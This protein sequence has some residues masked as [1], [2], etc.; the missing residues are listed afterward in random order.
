[1][2]E[3]QNK[4]NSEQTILSTKSNEESIKTGDIKNNT[5]V[6][7]GS[8][9]T[10][11]INLSIP[12]LVIVLIVVL[13][14]CLITITLYQ[15]IQPI[16]KNTEAPITENNGVASEE[17]IVPISSSQGPIS[18]TNTSTSQNHDNHQGLHA[19]GFYLW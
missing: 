4:S 1:M 12:H 2:L 19:V 9:I 16:E 10:Q 7:I 15:T 5:G 8:N 11:N 18:Q 6:A 3:N 13:L 17:S 14:V